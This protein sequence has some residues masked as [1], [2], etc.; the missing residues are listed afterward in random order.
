MSDAA[1]KPKLTALEAFHRAATTLPL[2]DVKAGMKACDML[3]VLARACVAAKAD[4]TVFTP[5][6][7]LDWL[8]A[9]DFE[10]SA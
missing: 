10:V 5:E 4:N 9:H 3:K 8:K 2:D 7:L 1:P 6:S